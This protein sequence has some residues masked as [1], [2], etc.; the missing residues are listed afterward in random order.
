MD[1]INRKKAP[2]FIEKVNNY[3]EKMKEQI[4]KGL[5]KQ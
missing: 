5:K 4:R 3:G 2:D 1:Y